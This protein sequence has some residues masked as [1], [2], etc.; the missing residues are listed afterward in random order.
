[1]SHYW[2]KKKESGYFSTN[3]AK[4]FSTADGGMNVRQVEHKNLCLLCLFNCEK[5]KTIKIMS[6]KFCS[7]MM[8]VCVCWLWGHS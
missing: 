7:G 8:C 6:Y 4:L 1:M 2:T 5:W 3:R